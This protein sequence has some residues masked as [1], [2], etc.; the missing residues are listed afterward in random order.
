MGKIDGGVFA[1]EGS[2]AT[3]DDGKD[4]ITEY[5]EAPPDAPANGVP[6]VTDT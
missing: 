6:A 1:P 2:P 3:T 4:E 5:T